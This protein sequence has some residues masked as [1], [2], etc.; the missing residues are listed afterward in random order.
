MI[1][2][3]QNVLKNS[4]KLVNRIKGFK[5]TARFF[6]FKLETSNNRFGCEITNFQFRL[7]IR[8]FFVQSGLLTP[9]QVLGNRRKV[10]IVGVSELLRYK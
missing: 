4:S 3:S 10:G 7:Q 8:S 1:P 5:Q 2:A 9:S 6:F